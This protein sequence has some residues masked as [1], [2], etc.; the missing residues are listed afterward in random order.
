MLGGSGLPPLDLSVL[1][2]FA[3]TALAL[4][5]GLLFVV[6]SAASRYFVVDARFESDIGGFVGRD[7]MSDGE[8]KCFVCDRRGTKK[9]SRCKGVRYW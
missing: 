3:I 5:S 6:R 9:C 4:V 7:K 1:L 8:D 2:Q